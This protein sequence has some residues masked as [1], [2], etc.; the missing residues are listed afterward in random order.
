[1]KKNPSVLYYDKMA[2]RYSCTEDK[3]ESVACY[4]GTNLSRQA[5][6]PPPPFQPRRFLENLA[7][8]WWALPFPLTRC[9]G[10]ACLLL[11]VFILCDTKMIMVNHLLSYSTQFRGCNLSWQS[12]LIHVHRSFLMQEKYVKTIYTSDIVLLPAMLIAVLNLSASWLF[13]RRG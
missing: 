11:F 10:V 4:L 6:L 5:T 3:T 8:C 13:W 7:W 9:W 1:M 12:H 2:M